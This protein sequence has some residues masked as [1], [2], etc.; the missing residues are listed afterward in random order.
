ML[1]QPPNTTIN[2]WTKVLSSENIILPASHI[3]EFAAFSA[4]TV[5]EK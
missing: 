5:N 4:F 1:K 2:P 3:W